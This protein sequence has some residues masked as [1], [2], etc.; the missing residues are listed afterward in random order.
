MQGKSAEIIE[1]PG[2]CEWV[3]IL[4]KFVDGLIGKKVDKGIRNADIRSPY[5]LD[6]RTLRLEPRTSQ[7]FEHGIEV[8]ALI[9]HDFPLPVQE[10]KRRDSAYLVAL[11]H[12]AVFVEQNRI[13][14]FVF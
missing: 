9:A 4:G 2:I 8:P 5:P 12:L 14:E 11:G 13:R 6:P 10:N 1:K 3:W 7:T